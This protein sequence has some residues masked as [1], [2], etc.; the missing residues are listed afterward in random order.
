MSKK[1]NCFG[2]KAA[3]DALLPSPHGKNFGFSKKKN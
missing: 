1:K 3:F 2:V